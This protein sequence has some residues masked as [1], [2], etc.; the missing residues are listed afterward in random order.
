MSL[1]LYLW[2]IRL[3]TLAALLSWLGVVIL[4]DPQNSGAVGIALF[5][6]SLLVLLTGV[7]TLFVTWVYR[8]GLGDTQT[9][10]HL[11][12]AFRQA[13]LLSLY[14]IG[15]IIFQYIQILTWWDAL[16]LFVAVLLVEF[17]CRRFLKHKSD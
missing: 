13:V 16:L 1:S 9:A 14:V 17:S 7:F 3:F 10:H 8:K 5:S 6:V 15:I 12:G 11:S 4:L 2:G